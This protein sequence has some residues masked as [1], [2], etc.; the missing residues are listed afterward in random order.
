[1]ATLLDLFKSQKRDLY[2]L[3]G[4][5]IIESRG[6]I[7]PPRGAA[8]LT[9]SPDTL[10]D[11]IGN[12]IGGALKGSAN[13]PSDTIFRNNTPFAKPISLFKTQNGLK[14]AIDKDT[15]Y[16]IKKS[17]APASL[18]ASFIQGGS[19]IGG[20][21]ANLA[22]KAVTK[23]GLKE[24]SDNLK[25]KDND[26]VFGPKFSV[27][28]NGKA[29]KREDKKFSTHYKSK[30]GIKVRNAS[31]E[32]TAWDIGK[33]KLLEA[34]SITNTELQNKEYANHVIATFETIPAEG[35]PPAVKIPFVGSISGISE[36][37]TPTWNNFKYLGSPFSI[38]RYNGV[39]RSLR[40]NLKLYYTTTLERNAMITKIN[41]LKSLAFPDTDVKAIA[42]GTAETGKINSQYAMAPNL[43]KISIGDLY[44]ELPGFIES[45]SFEIDDMT[46]WPSSAR[47]DDASDASFLYPSVV[48]V[49][50]GFKIIEN[51]PIVDGTGTTKTYRYNFDGRGEFN[52]EADL[53]FEKKRR[54][55]LASI[56]PI[57]L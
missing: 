7:N 28:K 47:T 55:L 36:E 42:F 49:S 16:F 44:K 30:T 31:G 22:I 24:L 15:A 41:Y 6:L 33:K 34:I 12:Q 40:F 14:R 17:P 51:H 21:A 26:E 54:N 20:L 10:A 45:L 9:S 56:G 43:V 13:R 38:Y 3:S 53:E 29:I 46:N 32:G 39:E 48:D 8:L 57:Q 11:L 5:A 25:K 27:D 37:V 52:L 23:G 2:G 18:I 1:M 35:N 4:G 50:I 19:S